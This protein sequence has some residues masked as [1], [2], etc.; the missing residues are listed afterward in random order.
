MAPASRQRE[1]VV[2]RRRRL[3]ELG[4]GR[5][6][7]SHRDD[8]DSALAR[9]QARDVCGH[10]RLADALAGPDHRQ[11]RK[12]E[13]FE[14]RRLEMEVRADVLQP[15]DERAARQL[16]SLDRRHHR[17]VRE[18]DDDVGL[19]LVE[20]RDERHAVALAAAKLLCPAD[21]QRTD[22][23]VRERCERGANHRRVMLPVDDRDRPHGARTSSSIRAVYFWNSRVSVEN[24]MI[25]SCPWYG[26]RRQTS[27]CACSTSIT[28]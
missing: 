20:R 22:E 7:S 15:Q 6:A 12:V 8:D 23:L 16:E 28:L 17:L 3:D 24:W 27:T 11:R 26:Y 21:E 25:F 9:E 13:R 1:Q 5:S 19:A 14:P 2:D 10:R 4:L 18:V